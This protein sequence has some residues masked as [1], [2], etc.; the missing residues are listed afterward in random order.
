MRAE[1]EAAIS[2]RSE[3][4]ICSAHH[5]DGDARKRSRHPFHPAIL[6]HADIKTTEIYTHV[7]IRMLKQ[8]YTATHPTAFI[9]EKKRRR[10]SSLPMQRLR[11]RLL[12]LIVIRDEDHEDQ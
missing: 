9:E 5:G 4:V 11:D 12:R 6:G 10:S 1:I 2:A 8:V 7:A 3:P